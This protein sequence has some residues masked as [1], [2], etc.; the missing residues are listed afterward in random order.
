MSNDSKLTL[1]EGILM[2]AAEQLGDVT[3]PAMEHYYRRNPEVRAA[4]D[5]H[6]VG[7]RPQLEGEM[8]E[9]ALYCLMYWFESPGEIEILLGGSVP[10][11]NDTLD[12]PP[13]WY[14]ELIDS[15]AAVIAATIPAANTEELAVWEE[16]RSDLRKL[17]D[18]CSKHIAK[19]ADTARHAG[20]PAH[21]A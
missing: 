3:Q 13:H 21:L 8:I 4:F 19:P 2:R 15:T 10:H 17:I 16:L 18:D 7:N 11:H 14:S 1:V 20:C 9:N 5:H 6:C 12:V